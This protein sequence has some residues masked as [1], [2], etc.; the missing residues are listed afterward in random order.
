MSTLPATGG[1][2]RLAPSTDGAQRPPR[3]QALV[4]GCAG[5]V[6]SHLAERLIAEGWRVRGIDAFTSHYPRA[7]KEANLADLAAE[8][9]FTLVEADLAEASL[10]LLVADCDAIFHLAAQAGVRPSFGDGFAGYAR[11]NLV[12]TQRV[13]EACADAGGTRVVWASSSSVYGQA[14]EHPVRE[15]SARRPRSPY[16]VTKAACEDLALVYRRAGLATVG[17]RYFSVYGPRQR[18]DMAVQRLCEAAI[19]DEPFT[20]LGDGHQERDLTFVTD[21][22]EA[23]WRAAITAR[24][25]AIYNIGAGRP[26]RLIDLV[27]AVGDLMGRP[28]RI[29]RRASAGGD[30]SRTEA[31]TRRA[32]RSL[33]WRPRVTLDEGLAAQ[34]QWALTAARLATA[35]RTLAASA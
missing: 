34:L 28:I 12:V 20:L 11:D 1:P 7:S 24:P 6:G 17:L 23:T 22:V 25:A 3:H 4:T 19:R 2:R 8:P 13:L 18:P 15:V 21:A 14:D 5:F 32:L 33:G 35:P 9:R 31:D 27:A 29:E 26:V 16:G 30:V 10:G